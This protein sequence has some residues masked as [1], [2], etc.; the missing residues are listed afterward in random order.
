MQVS[1]IKLINARNLVGREAINIK[2]NFVCAQ[3]D[4]ML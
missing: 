3:T 2:Q 4:M 1:S